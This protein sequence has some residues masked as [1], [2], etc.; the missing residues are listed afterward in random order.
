MIRSFY[1]AGSAMLVQRDRMD[2]LSSNLTNVETTGY[3]ADTL[4]HGSFRD[5]LLERTNDPEKTQSKVVGPLNTGT[6]IDRVFTSFTQGSLEQTG[7]KL[8]LALDGEGF[9]AVNTPEGQRFT[10]DG[11][12]SVNAEGYLVN[13]EGHYVQGEN[14][15]I[16]VGGDMFTV[17]AEGNIANAE[18][19][20]IARLRI[21]SFNNLNGLRKEGHNLFVNESA[22]AERQADAKVLQG[23]LEGSNVD[24]SAEL[25]RLLNVSRTYQTNQRVFMTVDSSL[26]K[27][28]NEV[29]R[30]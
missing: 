9:F 24:V 17:D 14:G 28:V 11:S 2:V 6:H 5:M 23:S 26:E 12:F 27:A 16:Q 3:K 13:S 1:T 15:R 22:G 25:T 8:D 29:G 10:R 20:N 4:Y 30:V 19:Q 7:R 21:V 18:G